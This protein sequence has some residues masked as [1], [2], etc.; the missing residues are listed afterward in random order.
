MTRLK[1]A[2]CLL[3]LMTF[4]TAC[5]STVTKVQT[6]KL[7]PPQELLSCKDAPQIPPAPR[8]QRDI[9]IYIAELRAAYSDCAAT[10]G[11]IRR[12]AGV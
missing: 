1:T 9:A 8:T 11:E 7:V 5:S 4:L 10:V 6:V 2:L 12:W 3:P